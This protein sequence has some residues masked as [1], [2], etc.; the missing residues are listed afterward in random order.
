M[1][2]LVADFIRDGGTT[3]VLTARESLRSD[4]LNG[5]QRLMLSSVTVPYLL[6]LDV[7]DVDFKVSLHYEITGKRMLSQCLKLDKIGMTEFFSLLLQ[8]VTALDDCHQYM[9]SPHNFALDE[10]RIFVEEPLASGILYFTYVPIK[11][12]LIEGSL[13]QSLFA[14]ITRMMSSVAMLEGDGIQ[15]LLR[16][17]S[18]ELFSVA[19]MKKMLL[20][21]LAED[22]STGTGKA[23]PGE[24]KE[25][26]KLPSYSYRAS[27]VTIKEYVPMLGTRQP[28]LEPFAAAVQSSYKEEALSPE[29]ADPEPE[30]RKDPSSGKRTYIVLGALLITGIIWKFVYLDHPADLNL[31][32][33]LALTVITAVAAICLR[34]N[35]LLPRGS[36]LIARF[37]G[38]SS[39][40]GEREE[41]DI[42]EKEWRWNYYADDPILETLNAEVPIGKGRLPAG[43]SSTDK[44][45]IGE[46]F[47]LHPIRYGPGDEIAPPV[48]LAGSDPA[49]PL[50]PDRDI[51][52]PVH[53]PSPPT[54][55]LGKQTAPD[56]G[57]VPAAAV[58]IF[59]LERSA[60]GQ[61]HPEAIPLKPGSFVIGRS[62]EIASY[63]DSS[64]GV[65][66]AHAELMVQAEGC[67]LKDL[68]S[69]NGTRL[70]GELIPPYKDHPL[71]PGDSF[72]IADST[73]TLRKNE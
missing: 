31:F 21:L 38:D 50:W 15:R 11:G 47:G 56:Q 14:L 64:V 54:V 2:E 70:R 24:L 58:I 60:P 40:S 46:H 29:V 35:S 69:R 27:P 5:V 7:R 8:I 65:S 36:S 3:M 45:L 48:P 68:G 4:Q 9:L 44:S 51:G 18:D 28:Q 17:C 16:F 25:A 43:E 71:N 42:P 23:D 34:S 52:P 30:E 61:S 6:R 62:E 26:G 41:K 33:C 53:T 57:A 72:M 66:R 49:P 59:S 10:E 12:K 67:D 55:F 20:R 1:P 19:E 13:S 39:A 32:I 37:F 22:C 73:Y 63:V